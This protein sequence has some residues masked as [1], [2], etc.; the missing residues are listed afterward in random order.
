MAEPHHLDPWDESSQA[1]PEPFATGYAKGAGEG[2][3]YGGAAV[4]VGALVFALVGYTVALGV[5]LVAAALAAWFYPTVTREPQV[6]AREDG[7]FVDGIGFLDWSA[8]SALTLHSTA[9][10]SIMLTKLV[11]QLNTDM[12]KAVAKP[13]RQ[14]FWRSLMMRN[15]RLKKD[16]DGH[17]AVVVDLHTLRMPPEQVLSRLRQFRSV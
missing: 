7:L 12:D 4:A 9:V 5:A 8:V 13:Q 6:G 14:P 11:I 3:V 10:R 1:R 16:A 17:P 2:I 15:W